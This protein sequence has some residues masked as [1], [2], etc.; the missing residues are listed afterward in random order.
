MFDLLDET[1][2]LEMRIMVEIVGIQNRRA[3]DTG[4]T[5][6]V[7]RLVLLVFASPGRDLLEERVSVGLA[8]FSRIEAW[9]GDQV[10]TIA[11]SKRG[12]AI[13]SARSIARQRESQCRAVTV[14]TYT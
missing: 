5:E 8:M 6:H 9:V 2:S 14:M 11:V 10:G 4:R 1:A 12:S 13:R 7:H 3:W